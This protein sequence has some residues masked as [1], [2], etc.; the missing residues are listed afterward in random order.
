MSRHDASLEILKSVPTVGVGTLTFWG[1]GLSDWVLFAT[2]AW[3]IV[4]ILDKLPSL[5]S[6]LA[7]F[8]EW[9]KK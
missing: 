6:K 5:F 1:V 8:M 3:T 4:L 2:L 9:L 7:S